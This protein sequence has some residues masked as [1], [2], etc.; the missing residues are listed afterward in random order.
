MR[1]SFRSLKSM[2][3]ERE[4]RMESSEELAVRVR[5]SSL[6]SSPIWGPRPD[7]CCFQLRVCWC[8]PALCQEDRLVLARAVIIRSYNCISLSHMSG[9]PNLEGQA[10]LFISSRDRLAHLPPPPALG[11]VFF[12]SYDWQGYGRGY[13]YPEP[14]LWLRLTVSQPVYQ[15]AE[16]SLWLVTRYYFL[17][18]SCCP[19]VA[20]LSSWGTLSDERSGLSFVILSL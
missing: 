9:S 6:L 15:G 18:E 7:F 12:A 8:G 2:E 10:P 20:V 11:S 3:R 16:P 1:L 19:K 14:T 4:K 5:R 13:S 17:S